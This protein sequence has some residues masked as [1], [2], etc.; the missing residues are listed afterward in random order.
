MPK[1]SLVIAIFH[2]SLKV[3]QRSAGHS[4]VAAAAYRSGTSLRCDV[5]GTVHDYRKRAGV[6]AV[7]VLKP[8]N[9]PAWASDLE[10]LFNAAEAS[11]Q[12][13]NSRLARELEISLPS[14]LNA[15]QRKGLARD[16]SQMLVDTYGVAVMMA[17]HAPDAR[18]DPRNHTRICCLPPAPWGRRGSQAKCA[19]SMTRRP[20]RSKSRRSGR[21][22][23]RSRTST[24]AVLV[25]SSVSITADSLPRP[26]T[27]SGVGI[28]LRLRCFRESPRNMKAKPRRRCAAGA[29][30]RNEPAL[31]RA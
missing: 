2:A 30:D 8:S 11:D 26:E 16:V 6:A 18:G 12:R 25:W 15:D 20:G 1:R 19:N 10:R 27:P 31:T 9:A 24:S 14:A 13:I 22:W 4:A 21:A 7:E 23:Q 17:I 3:F 5:T 28:W 29:S